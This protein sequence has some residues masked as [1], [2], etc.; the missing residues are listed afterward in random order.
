MELVSKQADVAINAT[1]NY[2]QTHIQVLKNDL[3]LNWACKVGHEGC[4]NWALD[5]FQK[6]MTNERLVNIIS[7]L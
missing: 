5:N 1:L 2:T 3:L 6:Y 7:M 4:V